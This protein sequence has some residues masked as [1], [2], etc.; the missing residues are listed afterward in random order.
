MQTLYAPLSMSLLLSSCNITWQLQQAT[1]RQP[2]PCLDCYL[3]EAMM[4][5]LKRYLLAILGMLGVGCRGSLACCPASRSWC[6]HLANGIGPA[7]PP[8]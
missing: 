2:R 4:R 8:P 5:D 7:R 6:R 3:H 1:C